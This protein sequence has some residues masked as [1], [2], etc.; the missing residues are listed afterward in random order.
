[1][2]FIKCALQVLC[3]LENSFILVMMLYNPIRLCINM[4]RHADY[5]PTFSLYIISI[6]LYFLYI[7][8]HHVRFFKGNFR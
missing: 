6:L 8:L 5:I 1:M 4:L 7:A 2:I 3:S